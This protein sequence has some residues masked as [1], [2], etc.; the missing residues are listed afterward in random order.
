MQLQLKKIFGFNDLLL[1]G[2]LLVAMVLGW[3]T[4]TAMQKNY[5]LQQKYDALKAEVE[6]NELQN[7]NLKYTIAYLKTEDYQEL[8]AREKFN[9]AFSGE[10]MV[11]LPGNGVATQAPVVKATASAAKLK[12]TGWKA[13]IQAWWHFLQGKQSNG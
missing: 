2:A 10:N 4:V 12:S 9:K 13:N 8:A 3:N 7:Q 5:R 6:L 11:Y 1:I